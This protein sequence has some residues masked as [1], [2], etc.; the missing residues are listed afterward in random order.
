M[1]QNWNLKE[2]FRWEK[3]EAR[4]RRGRAGSPK[5]SGGLGEAVGGW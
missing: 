1:P 5:K 2:P 3:K 4:L